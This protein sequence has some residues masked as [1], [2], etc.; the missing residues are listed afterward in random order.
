MRAMIFAAAGALL[1][2]GCNPQGGEPATNLPSLAASLNVPG[3]VTDLRTPS[4]T[5]GVGAYMFYSSIP[6]SP[7]MY[8]GDPGRPL[9]V[10]GHIYGFGVSCQL[11]T[12]YGD[13]RVVQ[14][15]GNR[16]QNTVLIFN[17]A[18]RNGWVEMARHGA[19]L[20]GN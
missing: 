3:D 12:P 4:A 9:I 16:G 6:R 19:V 2:A 7:C 11:P 18:G 15:M 1:L 8:L 17:Q 14:G 10:D 5:D 20:G 13:T